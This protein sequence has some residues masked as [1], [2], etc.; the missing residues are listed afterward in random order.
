MSVF[1]PY[2][3]GGLVFPVMTMPLHVPGMKDCSVGPDA[4]S[5]RR[6]PPP[7]RFVLREKKP[8]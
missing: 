1:N 6:T 2:S 5:Q 3:S 4:E 7:R 8:R